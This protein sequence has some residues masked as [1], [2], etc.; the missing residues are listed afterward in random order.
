MWNVY[1]CKDV[2]SKKIIPD[3]SFISFNS[4]S[5]PKQTILL[6]IG[7]GF[8]LEVTLTEA[9]PLIEKRIKLLKEKIENVANDI[10]KMRAKAT[11]VIIILQKTRTINNFLSC[12]KLSATLTID[13]R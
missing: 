13:K 6:E 2:N 4:Y 1:A 9:K 8:F 12:K 3:G 7:I 11:L 5:N 10:A